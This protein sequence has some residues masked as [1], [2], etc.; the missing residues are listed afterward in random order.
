MTLVDSDIR[1]DY[2][3]NQLYLFILFCL[4]KAR[5]IAIFLSSNHVEAV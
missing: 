2:Y 1:Q 3:K 5:R 4:I